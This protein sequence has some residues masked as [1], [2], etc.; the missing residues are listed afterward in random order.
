MYKKLTRAVKKYNFSYLETNSDFTGDP[1][2]RFLDKIIEDS[3]RDSAEEVVR[4]TIR[5]LASDHMRVNSATEMLDELVL[6]HLQDIQRELVSL[7][8]YI[9]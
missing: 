7:V 3:I 6:D 5:D 4:D 8:F 9:H 1:L 2:T